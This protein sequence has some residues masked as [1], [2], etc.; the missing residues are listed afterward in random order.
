MTRKELEEMKG[1][2]S[3]LKS[4]LE[5]AVDTREDIYDRLKDLGETPLQDLFHEID[6]LQD[7]DTI[8]DDNL[9]D[10]DEAIEELEK[11]LN[12]IDIVE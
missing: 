1:F 6:R 9:T 12:R 11:A 7:L 2:A 4:R 10:L 5:D 3:I 8:L